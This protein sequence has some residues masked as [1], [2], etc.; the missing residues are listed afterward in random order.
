MTLFT[1]SRYVFFVF[2]LL[3]AC[4]GFYKLIQKSYKKAEFTGMSCSN[5]LP[6]NP[7]LFEETQT[8]LRWR[9]VRRQMAARHV[10]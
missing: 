3:Y 10:S 2:P 6:T 8:H 4:F 1:Q 9:F 7:K 5:A